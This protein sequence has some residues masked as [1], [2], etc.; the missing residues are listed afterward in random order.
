MSALS[1]RRKALVH[2]D[3]FH[4]VNLVLGDGG[5]S[6]LETGHSRAAN[7]T[8]PKQYKYRWLFIKAILVEK[9]GKVPIFSFQSIFPI[10]SSFDS[11]FLFL[12]SPLTLTVGFGQD[13]E[14]W[15]S[16]YVREVPLTCVPLF[17]TLFC[18]LYKG[19]VSTDVRTFCSALHFA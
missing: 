9:K 1:L 12:P 7:M 18:M 6:L 5:G 4:A 3:H 8:E 14:L 2:F 13:C 16:E 19:G 15:L 10:F 17:F 11:A